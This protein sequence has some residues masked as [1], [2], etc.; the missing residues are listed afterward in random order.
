MLR[1]TD[2]VHGKSVNDICVDDTCLND[3][4]HGHTGAIV[5]N[6]PTL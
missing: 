5:D 6:Q 2:D 4:K 1:I 3:F